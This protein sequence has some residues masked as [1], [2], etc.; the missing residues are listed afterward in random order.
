MTLQ[1]TSSQQNVSALFS[2]GQQ[3]GQEATPW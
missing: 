2:L 1:Q 3:Q